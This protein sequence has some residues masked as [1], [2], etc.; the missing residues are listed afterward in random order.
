MVAALASASALRPAAMLGTPDTK[1][2]SSIGS[3]DLP[4]GARPSGFRL[5]GWSGGSGVD[6][7]G[8]RGF[9]CF[10]NDDRIGSHLLSS[11][12]ALSKTT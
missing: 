2:G 4:T 9:R 6:F 8:T 5:T 10:E 12:K 7:G 1:A 3:L 11:S